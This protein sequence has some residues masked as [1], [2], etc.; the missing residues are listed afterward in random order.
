MP[1]PLQGMLP[2]EGVLLKRIFMPKNDHFVDFASM[3]N[4]RLGN[5]LSTK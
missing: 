1:R 5:K 3:Q 4:F 2:I